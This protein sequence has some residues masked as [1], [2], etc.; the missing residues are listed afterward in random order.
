MIVYVEDRLRTWLVSWHGQG[1][2]HQHDYYRCGSCKS[3]VTHNAIRNG[4]CACGGG[5]MYGPRLSP[6]RLAWHEKVR[7]LLL[8]WTVQR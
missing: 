1:A 2:P 5:D 3:L 6:A 8:P 7:L 4:G